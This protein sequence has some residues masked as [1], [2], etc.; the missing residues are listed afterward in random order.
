V[1]VNGKPF[2]DYAEATPSVTITATIDEIPFNPSKP[3]PVAIGSEGQLKLTAPMNVAPFVSGVTVEVTI[4][5]AAGKD[6][7]KV[8][9]LP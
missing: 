1:F 3:Y 2:S 4:H 7:P 6:Y 8:V 5:T 9:V